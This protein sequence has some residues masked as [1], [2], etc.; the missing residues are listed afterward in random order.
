M[1]FKQIISF[2]VMIIISLTSVAQNTEK[3]SIQS[4]IIKYTFNGL[5][6]GTER[7]CFDDY[8]RHISYL[9]VTTSFSSEIHYDSAFILVRHDSLFEYDLTSHKLIRQIDASSSGEISRNFISP[10]IIAALGFNHVGHETIAGKDCQKYTN[11]SGNIWVWHNIVLKSET[12]IMHTVLTTEAVEIQTN[13]II[14]EE[15]FKNPIRNQLLT[16]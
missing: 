15:Y 6:Q 2:A 13:I 12:E 14:P 9:K 11:E 4:G 10:E 5:S 1:R 3:N 7:V 8:G 16:H